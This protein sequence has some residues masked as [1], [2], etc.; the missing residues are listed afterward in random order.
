[1]E[2]DFW[3]IKIGDFKKGPKNKITDIKGIKVGHVTY[4]DG[5]IKTGVTAII[6]HEG[7]IFREKLVAASHVINGFGK[8]TGLIQIDELG[9]LETPII[10]TNTLAVGKASS[11]LVSY[12]LSENDDIGLTTGTVN[13]IVLECNDGYLNDIR[14]PTIQEKDVFD[15]IKNA[16][17]DFEEGAVGSGTGMICYKLKGGIG[18]SSR[19]IEIDGKE[20]TLGILVMTNFGRLKDLIVDG[21][22]LGEMIEDYEK[23]NDE[24]D[25]GSI[26][27]ILAT[28]IPLSHRQLS[29][30]IRRVQSGIARTG[31]YTS[32]Q[33][34]EVVIGFSTANR[35][36]HYEKSSFIDLKCLS[37]EKIDL[38]FQ[39]TV[40]ATQEA[41]LKSLYNAETKTGLNN[42]VINSIRKYDDLWIKTK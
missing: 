35:L 16:S 31:S 6:P 23:P 8:S 41:I 30:V 17:E 12:M 42:R 11:G 37:E 7:N 27:T 10:L 40:F 1:M 36:L 22:P 14:K 29:R 13:P 2:K 28:D 4:D 32:S 18:S 33:S 24:K 15:A 38:V 19:I 26:I 25:Q 3:D 5:D 9:T 21:N 34:G 20:Y 39:A